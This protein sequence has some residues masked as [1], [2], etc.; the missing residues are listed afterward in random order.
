[1]CVFLLPYNP[2]PPYTNTYIHHTHASAKT[3][4]SILYMS[5]TLSPKAF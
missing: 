5:T 4:F 1:M 3:G 2:L